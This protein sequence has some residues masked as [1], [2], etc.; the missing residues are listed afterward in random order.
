MCGGRQEVGTALAVRFDDRAASGVRPGP[1]LRQ[2]RMPALAEVPAEAGITPG[3]TP[4]SATFDVMG[5][6]CEIAAE[7]AENDP[8]GVQRLPIAKW[9][10]VI[11]KDVNIVMNYCLR[12]MAA[13]STGRRRA[14]DRW[15]ASSRRADGPQ[16]SRSR[17]GRGRGT[18]QTIGG[19]SAAGPTIAD[20]PQQSRSGRGAVRADRGGSATDPTSSTFARSAACGAGRLQRRVRHFDS[21]NWRGWGIGGR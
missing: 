12:R 21:T 2:V 18:E 15:R 14:G 13:R 5:A 3:V 8:P 7:N 1:Y 10:R 9:I 19:S 20:G 17:A 6:L 16:Q 11:R 4:E